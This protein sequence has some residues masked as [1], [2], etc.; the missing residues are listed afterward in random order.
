ME[1]KY[2]EQPVKPKK[3]LSLVLL[4]FAN[5]TMFA[6]VTISFYALLTLNY[7]LMAIL[8][9]FTI[10]QLFVEKPN[11]RKF[12]N[13]TRSSILKHSILL[14]LSMIR[15]K[16]VLLNNK[17]DNAFMLFILTV[18]LLPALSLP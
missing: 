5:L 16:T 1:L 10:A 14:K 4:L 6:S 3:M 11:I 15:S 8:L 17:F 2:G 9:T 12:R 18:F 13:Q 7:Q